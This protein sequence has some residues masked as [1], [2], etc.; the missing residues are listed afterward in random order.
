[1]RTRTPSALQKMITCDGHEKGG[2]VR[3]RRTR[4]GGARHTA[5]H[6]TPRHATP[7]ASPTLPA[8][9]PIASCEKHLDHWQYEVET[10]IAGHSRSG[11]V[12]IGAGSS[13]LI[14]PPAPP[15]SPLG[16]SQR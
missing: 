6:A 4:E 1:M 2:R 16:T 14:V 15:P 12:F 10:V 5:P 8:E 7:R 11:C 3:T 13:S 9:V